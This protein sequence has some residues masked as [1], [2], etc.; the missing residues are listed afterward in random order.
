M[1]SANMKTPMA[2][3]MIIGRATSLTTVSA[4]SNGRQRR[5]VMPM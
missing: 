5:R 3:A 1:M 4:W 2:F